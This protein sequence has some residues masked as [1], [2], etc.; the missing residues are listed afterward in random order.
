MCYAKTDSNG[1]YLYEEELYQEYWECEFCGKEFDTEKGCLFHENV[2]CSKSHK[3]YSTDDDD[4]DDDII[5]FRCG[6]RGHLSTECYAKK[7]KKGYYL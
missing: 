6:H 5:C 3:T 4:D 2:H 1:V 7:H